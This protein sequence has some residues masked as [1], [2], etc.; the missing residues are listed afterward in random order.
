MYHRVTRRRVELSYATF[1]SDS[2][3][4]LFS[5]DV[6]HVKFMNIHA[7]WMIQ[8]I[9]GAKG[10]SSV[11]R[12]TLSSCSSHFASYA[13]PLLQWAECMHKSTYHIKRPTGH[14]TTKTDD[15][16]VVER[17]SIITMGA[18]KY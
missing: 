18:Q 8:T 13:G 17:M 10:I 7:L 14:C 15:Q 9:Y 2:C 4:L 12:G 6:H 16:L 3:H 11:H 5:A 1:D